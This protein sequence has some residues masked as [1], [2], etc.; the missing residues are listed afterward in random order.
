MCQTNDKE[1]YSLRIP[2]KYMDA[3]KRDANMIG[4]TMSAVILRIF[5]QHYG[6]LD[7]KQYGEKQAN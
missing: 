4:T 2:K 1:R 3:V 7:E 6:F 5:A